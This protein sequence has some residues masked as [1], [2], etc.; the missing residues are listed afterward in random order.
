MSTTIT[1]GTA[2]A[3]TPSTH[4]KR[5]GAHAVVDSHK[6]PSASPFGS[7]GTHLLKL[8]LSALCSPHL[9]RDPAHVPAGASK[10]QTIISDP[11]HSYHVD[12]DVVM[13]V[14]VCVSQ[15][16]CLFQHT[17]LLKARLLLWCYDGN[18]TCKA[19]T[20]AAIAQHL[21]SCIPFTETV[22]L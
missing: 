18:M 20:P 13:R 16:K 21:C 17:R 4:C 6:F 11:D 19:P 12:V 14:C 7:A 8:M 1:L 5:V 2:I 15:D 22:H 9:P 10:K 3:G